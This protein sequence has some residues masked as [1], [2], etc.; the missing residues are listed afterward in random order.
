M[1]RRQHSGQ[2]IVLTR[3]DS[4]A[5]TAAP[6]LHHV[7]TD[8]QGNIWTAERNSRVARIDGPSG[9]VAAV[10]AVAKKA[11]HLAID[12]DGA[13]LYLA[14]FAGAEL[15][16]MDAQSLEVVARC[17]AP[18]GPQLPVAAP[19]SIAA[20]TGPGSNTLTILRR[21]ADGFAHETIDIGATPH[22]SVVAQDGRTLYVAC[23]GGGDIARVDLE[24]GALT[25]RIEAGAGAGHLAAHP[26]G[27][28]LLLC[29]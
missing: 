7:I 20:V 15:V 17:P 18:G 13:W 25:G 22:D 26:D 2:E 14:D 27:K 8:G 9:G 24:T 16:V 19:G 29:E 5:L 12:P 10:A 21:Q 28:S 11:S 6:G 1:Q 3:A 4:P 23:S